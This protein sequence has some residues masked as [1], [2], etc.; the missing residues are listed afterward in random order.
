MN[1]SNPT[2][3]WSEALE[4]ERADRLAEAQALIDR[5]VPHVGA[6]LQT[7]EL[8]RQRPIRLKPA[9]NHAGALAAFGKA[10]RFANF[11]ASCA[12][13]A[14]EGLA[15]SEQRDAFRATLVADLGFHPEP[16]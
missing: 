9:G 3:W 13:S 12:S 10:M 2:S 1:V 5:S 14:G 4:L 7:A 16:G 11:Y 6:S 8:F 15:F